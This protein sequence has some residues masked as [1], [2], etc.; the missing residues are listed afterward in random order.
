ML[1]LPPPCSRLIVG[2][3]NVFVSIVESRS[4]DSS[5]A[6]L[7]AFDDQLSA[8]N[9]S[10][11]V[12]VNDQT[13]RRPVN[14]TTEHP[15]IEFLAAIRNLALAPLVARGG[16]ATVLFSN[17]IFFRAEQAVELLRTR[18]GAYDMACALDFGPWGCALCLCAPLSSR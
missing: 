10:R 11:R 15:R 18:G 12:L 14:M 9:V 17:D 1:L 4:R 8:L 16:Y 13:I 3:D 5:P 7:R 6:L 2:Q